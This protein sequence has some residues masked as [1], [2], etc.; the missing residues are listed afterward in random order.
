VL[1]EIVAGLLKDHMW[2]FLLFGLIA[3]SIRNELTRIRKALEA[4]DAPS[5]RARLIRCAEDLR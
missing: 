2:A 4:R 3:I 5:E 1:D